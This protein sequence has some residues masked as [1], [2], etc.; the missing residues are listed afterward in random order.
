[1]TFTPED[2]AHVDIYPPI[3]IARVGNSSEYFIGSEVPGVEPIPD[4]GFKDK[5]FKIKKQAARFRVYAYDKEGKVL[6]E[7]TSAHYDLKWTVHVANKKPAWVHF[8]GETELEKWNL[9]NGAVQGWPEGQE[10]TYEFTNTRTQLIIDSGERVIEGANVKDVFLDGVF[11]KDSDKIPHTE[12]RLGELRTDEQ[13]R[14]LVLPSD[15]HSF[16]VDGKE[17][18]DGFDN[19]RWVDNMSDGTV[20]VAVKPKSKPHD[21]PVKNRATIITAPPRFASGTHAATTLYELIEDIYERPRRKEAGYDV[22]IVD[23]YR[24][25]HPLF[26]RI[27]LLSW[28]NKTA[29]EGHGPDSISRFSGPKL[30]DPKEGNGTRVARFKK[31][32]A[33]EPNKHQEGP[34]DGKM[35]ELFGAAGRNGPPASLTQLQYDRLKKWS[36][37]KFETGVEADP[38]PSFDKIPIEEQPSALTRAA[39][40]WS[41]G[42][43]FYPGIE[44]YWHVQQDGVYKAGDR[45]RFADTV[46]P[47][48]LTRG[49]SLPWQSDFQN[50]NVKWWP[51]IR[52]DDVVTE[53]DFN[54][55]QEHVTSPDKLASSF[56]EEHRKPWNRGVESQSDMVQKWNKLGF[57]AR[58]SYGNASNLPEILVEMQRDPS[59]T[60]P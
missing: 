17:E 41:I 4:G 28:T 18:I 33:P 51:S 58:Q 15:G 57:V 6:G 27:Y 49:L 56:G 32:R 2:I 10:K 7:I 24:D 43:A 20:H 42:A 23:Y 12:V 9:R 19:D 38:H 1:M 39:L 30:S 55:Q 8:R 53:A 54:Q 5:D 25:I 52:P 3:A 40:E 50:C 36:G 21:I 45:F 22:G 29:L 46:T 16:S 34:T 37:G 14:L 26:K 59:I 44:C 48:D 13:G 11:G 35:P 47:G 60:P 31:I